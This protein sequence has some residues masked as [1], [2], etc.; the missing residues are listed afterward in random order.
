M[1]HF[2]AKSFPDNF[3]LITTEVWRDPLISQTICDILDTKKIKP[4]TVSFWFKKRLSCTLLTDNYLKT[5]RNQWLI[6]KTDEAISTIF[7]FDLS[8]LSENNNI[9]SDYNLIENNISDYYNKWII[10]WFEKF[11]YK[12]IDLFIKS[13]NWPKD[14]LNSINIIRNENWFKSIDYDELKLLLYN[15]VIFEKDISIEPIAIYW[16]NKLSKEISQ[17]YNLPLFD[18]AESFYR[19]F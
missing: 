5:Y 14:L 4:N 1:E 11:K 18:S 10:K 13:F 17:K 8:A 19:N 12:D 15:E 3:S 7:P 9:V 2:F 6:F 16:I